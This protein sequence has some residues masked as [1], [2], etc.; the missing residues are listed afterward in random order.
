MT[1]YRELM[2]AQI[3]FDVC[4][5]RMEW[6]MQKRSQGMIYVHPRGKMDVSDIRIPEG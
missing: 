1:T 2:S 5:Y 3:D 4:N 6:I